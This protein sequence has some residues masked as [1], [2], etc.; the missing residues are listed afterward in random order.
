MLTD[1]QNSFADTLS[2][3]FAVNWSLK[4]PLRLRRV[5]TLPSG[6]ARNVNWGAVIPLPP[7]LPLFSPPSLPPLSSPFFPSLPSLPSPPLEVDP[8]N[9]ARVLGERC[10]L[11]SGVWSGALAEIEFDAF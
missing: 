5:T 7:F 10:K 2:G 9:T 3:I 4:I 11:P 8:L 6:V 1:F